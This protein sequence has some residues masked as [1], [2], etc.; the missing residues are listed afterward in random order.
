MNLQLSDLSVTRI[1]PPGIAPV[2]IFIMS[3]M[4][5][6]QTSYPSNPVPIP[7]DF[8]TSPAPSTPVFSHV[9]FADNGLTAYRNCTAFTLTNVLSPEECKQLL[10]LAEDSVPRKEG[11][12]A[13]RPAMVSLGVGIET[14]APGYRNSDRIIWDQQVVADRIWE[15]CAAVPPVKDLLQKVSNRDD[16]GEGEWVLSRLNDRLRF[17]KYTEGQFFKRE[18][19]S[20]YLPLTSEARPLIV[21]T[22]PRPLRRAVRL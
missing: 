21:L 14:P 1:L 19:L 10:S 12:S 16:V 9:P 11:D 5:L 8:L 13:W 22:P 2:T 7:D 20:P 4:G 6:F 17:L 15:R 18:S 3:A